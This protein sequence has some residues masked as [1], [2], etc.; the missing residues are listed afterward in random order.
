MSDKKIK[1]GIVGVH[2]ERGW[3]GIAHVPALQ[4]LPQFEIAAISNS[5]PEQARLAAAKF[6][7]ANA[8]SSTDELVSHPDVDLV[9]V[10]VRVPHH[11][12]IITKAIEAG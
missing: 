3:A 11:L 10:T 1:V 9:V 12:A 7:I 2:P 8:V 4:A 6:G 5:D